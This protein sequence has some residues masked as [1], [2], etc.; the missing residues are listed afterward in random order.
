MGRCSKR[1]E[2]GVKLVPVATQ[3]TR[4]PLLEAAHISAQAHQYAWNALKATW[5]RDMDQVFRHGISNYSGNMDTYGKRLL[6][7]QQEL[8]DMQEIL[9]MP[10]KPAANP[11][12]AFLHPENAA[13]F[14]NKLQAAARILAFTKPHGAK[15]FSR[16]EAAWNALSL[17]DTVPGRQQV[18][19]KDIDTFRV[20]EALPAHHG[21]SG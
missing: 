3:L 10:Y 8:D 17:G 9:D 12:L 19:V 1:F 7:N 13:I 18:R 16:I 4:G 5:K 21:R 14:T 15:E 2:N 11:F 20:L 6:T